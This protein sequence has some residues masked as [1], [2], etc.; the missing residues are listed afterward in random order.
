MVKST[1][2][3]E[4]EAKKEEE[5]LLPKGTVLK[6]ENLNETTTREMLRETLEKEY[7]ETHTDMAVI[8]YS[9]GGPAASLRFKE[10][11]A[12]KNLL[13]KIEESLKT[14]GEEDTAVK[15]FDING[16]EVKFGVL[17]G[18]EETTFLAKCL[19]DMTENRGRNRGGGH[20][21]R[22]GFQRGRGGKRPRN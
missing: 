16:A 18:E 6:L 10:E 3:T 5:N 17:E 22:G 12:A 21:R 2:D 19:P 8:Y 14:V 9:K 1:G 11:N 15:K 13:T 7:G 4:S 20:K